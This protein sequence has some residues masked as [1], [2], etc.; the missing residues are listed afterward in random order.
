VRPPFFLPDFVEPAPVAPPHL[1]ED[2]ERLF[3][4]VGLVAPR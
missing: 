1:G 2:T 3:A 4:E